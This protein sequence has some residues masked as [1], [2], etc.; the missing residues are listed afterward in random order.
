MH[1]PAYTDS[2]PTLT[3]GHSA[4]NTRTGIGAYALEKTAT[5]GTRAP[6]V[7]AGHVHNYERFEHNGVVYLTPAVAVPNLPSSTV[8]Q[9][10]VKSEKV[11]IITS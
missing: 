5:H 3:G 6:L 4:R 11:P 8:H 7:I 9:R 1:H 10:S 2:H